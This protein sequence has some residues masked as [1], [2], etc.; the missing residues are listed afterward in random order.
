MYLSLTYIIVNRKIFVVKIFSD[1]M[2]R[3]KI[4]HMNIMCIIN[5]NAVRGHLSEN[6][7]TRKLIARTLFVANYYRSTVYYNFF[8]A[9]LHTEATSKVIVAFS[10]GQWVGG[11][12]R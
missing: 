12:R 8:G 5:A 2:G 10:N 1:S 7:L 3:V 11:Y 6:Y 4:K 9:F